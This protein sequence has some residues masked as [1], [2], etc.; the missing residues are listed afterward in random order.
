MVVEDDGD[1]F[2]PTEPAA[3]DQAHVGLH[4]MR[5]RAAR[6][7]ASLRIVAARGTGTRVE[8]ILPR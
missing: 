5:E 6:L 1:G 3:D 7:S 4:I 2:D 8:L